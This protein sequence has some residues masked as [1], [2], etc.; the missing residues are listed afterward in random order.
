MT[1]PQSILQELLIQHAAYGMLKQENA[2]S[3]V[4]PTKGVSDQSSH[5]RRIL[6]TSIVSFFNSIDLFVSGGRDGQLLVWDTR[7]ADAPCNANSEDN[8]VPLINGQLVDKG[9]EELESFTGVSFY[10]DDQTILSTQSNSTMI[11]VWDL[12]LMNQ[13]APKKKKSDKATNPYLMLRIDKSLALQNR[14]TYITE[15][16]INFREKVTK[17]KE[18]LVELWYN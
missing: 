18:D 13:A 1:I 2:Y 11:K 3:E 7:T 4:I 14:I 8:Y 16:I 15:K 10:N 5:A 6:V 12:R 17:K 9:K